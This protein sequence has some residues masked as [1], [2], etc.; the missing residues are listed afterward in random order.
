MGKGAKIEL[1]DFRTFCPKA[2]AGI[3]KLP[4]TIAD[5]SIPIRLKRKAPGEGTVERFRLRLIREEAA[6]L[7]QRI[8]EWARE[9][10]ETLRLA[11]PALPVNLSDRQQDGAEP[12][13]GIVD[14]MGDD[15]PERARRSIVELFSGTAGEDPS[16]G[17]RLLTDIRLVFDQRGTDRLGSQDLVHGLIEIESSFWASGATETTHRNRAIAS[18][19]TLRDQ[20]SNT[21]FWRQ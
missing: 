15:W 17:V 4:D 20:S 11:A 18:P 7:R 5:R 16:V 6:D 1:K 13:L 2:L 21:A 9:H 14:P 10:V 8:V 19:A 3:G 12:L